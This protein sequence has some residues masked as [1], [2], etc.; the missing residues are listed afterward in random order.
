MG[1]KGR[2][3]FS[4]AV[5]ALCGC[6]AVEEHTAARASNSVEARA[7]R[8]SVIVRDSIYVREKADTVFFTRYRTLYKEKIVRDTLVVCDTLCTE[9]VVTRYV[10][11]R[12]DV[13]WWLLP[14]LL[15]L[16]LP[17]LLPSVRQFLKAIRNA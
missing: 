12:R 2:I 4:L 9:R 1:S 10:E 16:L 15:L 11:R 3:W 14:L 8:D 6:R 13:A 17:Q 5:L 7:V